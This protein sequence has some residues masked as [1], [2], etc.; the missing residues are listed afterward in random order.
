MYVHNKL[1]GESNKDK[2]FCPVELKSVKKL[3]LQTKNV[4][5]LQFLIKSGFTTRIGGELYP[6]T[7]IKES[8]MA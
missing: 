5:L 1:A 4:P 8:T 2:S 7:E 6:T 3:Q